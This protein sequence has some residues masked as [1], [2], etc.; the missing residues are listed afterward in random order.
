M[1][2]YVIDAI[3]DPY[4]PK[5]RWAFRTDQFS[6]FFMLLISRVRSELIFEVRAFKD[7]FSYRRN[8]QISHAQLVIKWAFAV[9]SE[10]TLEQLAWCGNF[11]D[12]KITHMAALDEMNP[13]LISPNLNK[14]ERNLRKMKSVS[15]LW[16]FS[17]EL[18]VKQWVL[19]RIHRNEI[20][21]WYSEIGKTISI[22][23]L[24][25]LFF[26]FKKIF[27]FLQAC[28][29][30]KAITGDIAAKLFLYI[31]CSAIIAIFEKHLDT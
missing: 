22:V 9:I 8:L 24:L 20:Y 5:D 30:D 26:C 21:M 23:S 3:I 13:C 19:L 2:W 1:F 7:K 11:K 18:K 6:V 25:A 29:W 4:K 28:G 17:W 15:N 31:L 27:L 10:P 12:F 14:I 16:G